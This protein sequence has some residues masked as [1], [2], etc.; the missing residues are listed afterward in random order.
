MTGIAVCAVSLIVAERAA[1]DAVWLVPEVGLPI[2]ARDA[3]SNPRGIDAGLSLETMNSEHVGYGLAVA[4]HFWP[5]APRYKAAFDR[6]L[7]L[8]RFQVING[9][10]WAFKA[11]QVGAYLKL[12]EPL[13][14]RQRAWIRLGGAVY[15]IDRN[16][17]KP[18]YDDAGI[19]LILV[20]YAGDRVLVGGWNAG[21]GWDA[22]SRPHVILGVDTQ[23]H[24]VGSES[25]MLA[26]YSVYT[27]GI[28]LGFGR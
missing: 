28:H 2:P 8:S 14:K 21:I 9:A 15:F 7:D 16:I 10:T 17:G 12:A 3:G 4:Y 13:P 5:A 22:L 19:G 24:Q 18:N 26:E 11:T 6:Y 20:S 27:V 23:F 25:P 1:A